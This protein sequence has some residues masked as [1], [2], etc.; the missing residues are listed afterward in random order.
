[1][2]S[3]KAVSV[4]GRVLRVGGADGLP[5]LGEAAR[6]AVDGDTIEVTAGEYR[7]DTAVWRQ[8]GLTVR[9]IGGRVRLVADG[10]HAEGKGIWVVKGASMVVQGLDFVGARVPDRNGAG[11]RFERGH[12]TLRR[13]RFLDNENGVLTGNDGAAELHLDGCEFGHNGA[14]DG[15][16]HNLY[17]GAIRRLQV[18]ACRLHHARV[19]HLLKS[20]AAVTQVLYSQLADG[21]DGQASYEADFANGGHVLMLGNLVQQSPR[22][23]NPALV[24]YGLEGPRWP[25][26]RLVLVHN[27]FVD[28]RKLG[29]E[30]L[31]VGPR[32]PAEFSTFNNVVD[33]RGSLEALL[34]GGRHGGNAYVAVGRD[35]LPVMN[36]QASSAVALP[37][38]VP[39][40]Q[41][42]LGSDLRL[43]PLQNEPRLPG[44]RQA[45]EGT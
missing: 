29:G 24:A 8:Q 1:M 39:S 23:E 15:Y 5:S 16:S 28:L 4:T 26:N 43:R 30:L 14:G 22:T 35:G 20:R 2:P 12:L 25:D 37:P 42:E 27:T 34:P 11:I 10:A 19:G 33:G 21:T 38:D 40:P 6:A 7:G 32:V 45:S 17:V 31:R 3:D 36:R 44:A 41:L 13:C 9:A 18:V